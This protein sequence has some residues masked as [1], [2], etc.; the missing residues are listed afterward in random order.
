MS[1]NRNDSMSMQ[2]M[3]CKGICTLP[4]IIHKCLL[5]GFYVRLSSSNNGLIQAIFTPA[6]FHGW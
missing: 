1:L 2:F 3:V 6:F 4:E 5:Y